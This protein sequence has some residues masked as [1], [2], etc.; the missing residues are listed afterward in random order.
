MKR[1]TTRRRPQ[2]ISR[3][4]LRHGRSASRDQSK[5]V[6]TFVVQKP[7]CSP[8][9]TQLQEALHPY[10]IP[11]YNLRERVAMTD[12]RTLARRWK[13]EFKTF[14]NLKYGGVG[15]VM[16]L[17]GAMQARF[18][19]PAGQAGWAEDLIHAS[20]RFAVTAGH[21]KG[22]GRDAKW[23]RAERMP[24][25]WDAT[26]WSNYAM[27]RQYSDNP[28]RPAVDDD[29]GSE[30]SKA[31]SAWDEVIKLRDAEWKRKAEGRNA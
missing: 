30:C 21:I 27:R 8:C 1:S 26:R 24:Q 29:G 4:Q 25:A 31:K 14:E 17:P 28:N 19:V 5:G 16:F 2:R 15:V 20:G 23:A 10:G 9:R 3:E 18:R 11:V 12:L 6:H 13:I 22:R 7:F